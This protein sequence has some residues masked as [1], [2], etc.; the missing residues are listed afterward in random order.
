MCDD[1]TEFDSSQPDLI[2]NGVNRRGF[3][4]AAGGAGLMALLPTAL[5]AALPVKLIQKEV[6]VKTPDGIADCHFAAPAK[7]RH[8]GVIVWPDIWGVRPAF[9]T[10]AAQLASAGY[11]VL[12][13]NPYYRTVKSP[14]VLEGPDM[15]S[16][17]NFKKVR[18]LASQ[19]T[20]ATNVTDASAFIAY[21]D[22][23]RSVDTKRLIGTTGYCMG[24]P[25]VMRA[26]AAAPKRIGAGASFHGSGTAT[27]AADSPHLLVPQMKGQYLFAVA[28][29]DDQR[30]PNEKELLKTAY[31]AAKLPAEIEVYAGAKH[32]WCPPG[33]PAH[34]PVQADR[35][36]QRLIALFG[37]AL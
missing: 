23:Q 19:L 30:N 5:T 33:G 8:P 32:G 27:D 21:L 6:M 14:V 26:A 3:G 24:G 35:A 11:A 17:A 37:R 1:Q 15:R 2:S 12:T 4:V 36:F 22:K 34:N 13:I 28:E 16:D 7:G 31:A 20:A 10:M 25:M 9:R 29:N 18:E